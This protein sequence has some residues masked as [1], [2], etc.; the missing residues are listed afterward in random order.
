MNYDL[1]KKDGDIQERLKERL[2]EV[3]CLNRKDVNVCASWVVTLPQELMDKTAEEQGMFFQ[4]TFDFL[5]DRYG[6]KNVLGANVHNDETTPHMHFTFIPVTYDKKK[7]REK[8][9]TKEVVS[10]T[11][12][13]TFHTDLHD[14]LK[15]EIPH[16]YE[17]G[18]LNDK[19]IGGD[20]VQDLK[21]YSKEIQEQKDKMTK[22]L[23]V[24]KEPQKVLGKVRENVKEK[25]PCYCG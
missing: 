15:Q 11:D 14:F 18:I 2:N 16:I 5:S 1:C 17:K 8:V 22:K 23:K 10:R 19:T 3:Y 7:E 6:E 24:F 25:E 13:R 21:K 12:L 20:T 9:S 4:R